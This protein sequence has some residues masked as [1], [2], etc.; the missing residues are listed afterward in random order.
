MQNPQAKVH[1]YVYWR[2]GD[3]V[4]LDAE[5]EEKEK[6]KEEVTSECSIPIVD[7]APRLE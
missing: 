5:G 1:C 2:G 6:F 7:N 4:N 3:E